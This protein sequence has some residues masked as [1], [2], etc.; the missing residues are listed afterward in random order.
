MRMCI[1]YQFIFIKVL[2]V[3]LITSTKV[4][5]IKFNILLPKSLQDNM[6]KE[7]HHYQTPN[8]KEENVSF[9]SFINTLVIF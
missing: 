1:K 6:N 8:I 7:R 5:E 2:I 3:Y 9:N 4:D